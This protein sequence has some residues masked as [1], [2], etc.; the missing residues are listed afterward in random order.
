[1][2]AQ[3]CWPTHI[4]KKFLG[5]STP[6][7]QGRVNECIVHLG[8]KHNWI[9]SLDLEDQAP[10]PTDRGVE[11]NIV[12]EEGTSPIQIPPYVNPKNF[13]YEAE[14]SFQNIK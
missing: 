13:R 1:M 14:N 7:P 6:E 2:G 4:P 8:Y 11:H 10:Q 5:G 3:N 12:L 9:I